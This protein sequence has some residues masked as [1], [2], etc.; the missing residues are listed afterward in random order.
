MRVKDLRELPQLTD[1]YSYLYVEHCKVD[2]EN[3]AIAIHD[4]AGRV[5]VPCAALALLML[6]PGTT[7]THAAVLTLSDNGCL[8]AW[9]GEQGTRFY[10]QGLGKN[11]SSRELERQARLFSDPEAR[12]RVVRM[13]YEKRF[14]EPL[15]SELTLEQIRGREG[16]RVRSTYTRM[17]NETGVPWSGRSYKR[18][19]WSNADPVN[20]A[21]SAA[22]SC[23]YGV[24]HAAIVALG[25]SPGLGFIHT[26][27]QLS[28]VYDIADLYKTEITIPIAFSAAAERVAHVES[29]VRH[30]CRDAFVEMRLLKRIVDDIDDLLGSEE[31]GSADQDALAADPAAPGGIWDPDLGEVDGGINYDESADGRDE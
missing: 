30:R 1:G 2:R 7:I 11:R 29:E 9:C 3:L 21:L 10:A 14:G 16:L 31:D 12:L 6:G 8:I 17:S 25:Y 15:S 20:R 19:S 23:L 4:A 24:C 26:G 5:S 28:F 13:M 27:K 22:N 18:D